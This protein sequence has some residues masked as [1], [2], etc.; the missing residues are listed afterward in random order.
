MSKAFERWMDENHVSW[1]S[2]QEPIVI[3]LAEQMRRM[4][5]AARNAG[6][7]EAAR[8]CRE[9]HG[10]NSNGDEYMARAIEA[11]RDRHE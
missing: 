6:L 5:D 8:I 3:A 10:P 11:E 1:R 7:T 2:R 9:R 4:W